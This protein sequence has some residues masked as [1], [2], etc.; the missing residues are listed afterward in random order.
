M[1]APSDTALQKHTLYL[2]EGDYTFLADKFGRG[3]AA[4][5]IRRVITNFVD[6]LDRPVDKAQVE[7]LLSEEELSDEQKISPTTLQKGPTPSEL[8]R[9]DD[10]R[11]LEPP[12]K[13]QPRGRKVREGV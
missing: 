13:R 11:T 8:S 5:V 12:K 9:R 6:S 3:K 7:A 4:L 2:R 10:E 1:P